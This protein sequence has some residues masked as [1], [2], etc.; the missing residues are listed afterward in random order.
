MR[1][2]GTD[3]G[4]EGGR[5]V[6]RAGCGSGSGCGGVSK[7]GA[8]INFKHGSPYVHMLRFPSFFRSPPPL[9]VTNPSSPPPPPSSPPSPIYPA[10]PMCKLSSFVFFQTPFRST[11][12][13]ACR[14]L[15]G[16]HTFH[17][18]LVL[19][20]A[21]NSHHSTRCNGRKKKK[22][23]STLREQVTLHR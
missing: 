3:R 18:P 21:R 13:R 19:S 4:M 20:P 2:G 17:T 7:G 22:K 12:Q 15:K 14:C 10:L 11:H 5:E 23:K 9:S 16:R 8:R 1:D 6:S